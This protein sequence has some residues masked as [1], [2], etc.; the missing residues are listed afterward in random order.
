[1]RLA[2]AATCGVSFDARRG[3]LPSGTS[4]ATPPR[5]S[6]RAHRHTVTG[7]TPNAAATCSWLAAFSRGE[8]NP[9]AASGAALIQYG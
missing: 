8:H 2:A 1:M 3:P 7:I 4:P 5:S 9:T 6:A